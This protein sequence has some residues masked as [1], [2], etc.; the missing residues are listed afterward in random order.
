MDFNKD[1]EQY[2]YEYD[3][4]FFFGDEEPEEDIQDTVKML[5][6]NYFEHLDTIID[7]RIDE[8]DSYLTYI[9][10]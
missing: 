9:E 7:I 1:L 8:V 2:V 3:G 6:D 4:L 10:G 5:A